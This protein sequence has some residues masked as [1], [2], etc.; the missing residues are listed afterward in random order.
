MSISRYFRPNIHQNNPEILGVKVS[1]QIAALQLWKN[2]VQ[3]IP[4]TYGCKQTILQK[5]IIIGPKRLKKTL[6]NRFNT[7]CLIHNV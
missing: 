2:E 3:T 5:G 7:Q 4:H 1:S 6:L